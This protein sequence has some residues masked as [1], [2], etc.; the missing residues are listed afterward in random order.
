MAAS[1]SVAELKDALKDAMERNGGLRKLQ[2]H[3]R[4][5][6]YRALSAAED[7]LRPE[8]S[9]E[10]LL[11]NELIREYLIFNGLRETLSVFLPESGQP[12]S[13]PF[14]R[15]FLSQQLNLAHTPHSAK[16]PLLYSLVAARQQEGLAASPSP[17]HN[18]APPSSPLRSA[19]ARPAGAA[20]EV[21][22][23][24]AGLA[25]GVVNGLRAAVGD[26]AVAAMQRQ[27]Y[28]G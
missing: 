26:A 8:P 7:A 17:Q 9:S 14:D 2:A 13:R 20:A 6:A 25:D 23:P 19:A 16:V 27:D 18:W 4:A 11:V 1:S 24:G 21:A 5:E 10:T 12:A 28:H 15:S 22:G 3:A